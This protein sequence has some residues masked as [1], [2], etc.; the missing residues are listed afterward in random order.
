MLIERCLGQRI[1]GGMDS[2]DRVTCATFEGSFV[3]RRG[4]VG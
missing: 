1:R 4:E 2:L 3:N